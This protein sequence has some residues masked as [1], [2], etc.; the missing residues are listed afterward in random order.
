MEA[1]T[2]GCWPPWTLPLY[3]ELPTGIECGDSEP[4]PQPMSS[5]S[6]YAERGWQETAETHGDTSDGKRF[7]AHK[8]TA[9]SIHR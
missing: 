9:V 4:E 6:K 1:P 7:L 8:G 2:T 3:C 5:Q